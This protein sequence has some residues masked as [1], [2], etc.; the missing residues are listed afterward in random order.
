LGSTSL[1]LRCVRCG[2]EASYIVVVGFY[3]LTFGGSMC[4]DCFNEYMKEQ[5]NVLVELR[6]R[7]EAKGEE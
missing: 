7:I 3:G 1:F 4:S 5:M 2:S 6:K